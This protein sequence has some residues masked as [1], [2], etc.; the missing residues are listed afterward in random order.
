MA[1][2]EMLRGAMT[3]LITPFRDGA[4]DEEALREL[5]DRQIGDGIDGLVPCGTTGESA[6]MSAQERLDV[7]R[8]VAEQV[9]GRVPVI[10]G[11]GTN[12]TRAT[13]DFT[14]EVSRI[15][16]VDAA[17][18]V[19]PYYNKPG[20]KMLQA[21]FEHVANASEL[22]VVLYNVPGRTVVSLTASA[23]ASLATHPD[24]IGIKEATG[25]L[26]FAAELHEAV[27]EQ[28]FAFMSGDDFTTMPFV[29]MG[30]HGCISV[31]SNIMPGT[32]STLVARAAGGD[33]EEA[34]ALN[35]RIQAL[36]RALFARS[37]PVPTKALASALGWCSPEVRAPLFEAEPE[38]IQELH[39]VF[40]AY[41]DLM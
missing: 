6:T 22:P 13:I 17:L 28:D 27:G 1:K 33:L 8:A 9:N 34:R 21:H 29:A 3:A 10:A 30:G 38:F 24:V 37:N 14:N 23:V 12:D 18:V 25:D 2:S 16:G 41:N 19:V 39:E 15:R 20:P 36:T 35:V 4:V 26:K 11:T 31:L 32:M 5:V 40:S 7:I